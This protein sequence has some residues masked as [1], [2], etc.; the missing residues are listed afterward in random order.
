MNHPPK[1]LLR[2]LR[3]FCRPELL[4]YIEGD[5]LELYEEN[6]RAKG[7]TQANWL[8]AWEVVKL[9]RPGVVKGGPYASNIL[10]VHSLK[11]SFRYFRRNPFY[12]GIN[13]LGLV[14]GI[15]SCLLI[16]LWVS[17]ERSFDSFH[18]NAD[19]LYRVSCNS[20]EFH[21][22]VSPGA[23][24][25][26]LAERYDFV[27]SVSR[28]RGGYERV[29]EAG[30]HKFKESKVFS[31]DENFFEMFTYPL[32]HGSPETALDAPHKIV[33]S[34]AIAFKYFGQSDAVGEVLRLDGE[35]EF[36][37]SGVFAEVPSNS[38]LDFDLV[39]PM[40]YSQS[41]SQWNYDTSWDEFAFR[42]YMEVQ[43]AA[44]D[45]GEL[46]LLKQE[47]SELYAVHE[48][49]FAVQFNIEPIESIHLFNDL[50]FDTDPGG[51]RL[52][53]QVLA[54][55][56]LLIVLIACINY[57]NF[58][59]AQ[60]S[61][62]LKEVWVRR[63]V[64][65]QRGQLV[66]YFLV[67]AMMYAGMGVGLSLGIIY[68]L[69]PLFSKFV[70]VS[71]NLSWFQWQHVLT[72]FALLMLVGLLAGVY[73]AF[74]LSKLNSLSRQPSGKG[75]YRWL[76]IR[77][78]LVLV[79]FVIFLG[80]ISANVILSKQLDFI[81]SKDLG[82]DQEDLIYLRM[83]EELINSDLLLQELE[84]NGVDQYSFV[85]DL[86]IN[87]GQ[88]NHGL[89]WEGK[90]PEL[91]AVI[92][93]MG[94]DKHFLQVFQA[95][96]VS[97]RFFNADLK[98]D[99]HHYVIN[100][101][102]ARLMGYTAESALGKWLDLHGKG[103]II[104][105]IED[106]HFKPLHLAVE[107]M[108]LIYYPMGNYLVVR[109]AANHLQAKMDGIEKVFSKLDPN[110]YF[111]YQYLHDGIEQLYAVENRMGRVFKLFV[112][113]SVVISCLGLI[114]LTS[115]MIDTRLKEIGIRKVLGVTR[116]GL[117]RLLTQQYYSLFVLSLVLACPVTYLFMSRWLEAFAY[118]IDLS[119]WHFTLS[120]G[121]GMLIIGVTV[122]FQL[123]KIIATNPTQLLRDE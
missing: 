112:F 102:A 19:R 41:V 35:E 13:L 94:A 67:E 77:S 119:F 22:A 26:A 104:G 70:E 3:W 81:R 51:D 79:Q 68:L 92:P 105:V 114:G 48:P 4:R 100:E 46:T 10:M 101:S 123:L 39:V 103:N 47:L 11:S 59:S 56:A 43:G 72:A 90:D 61:A 111:E 83:S 86:P 55:I 85:S 33:I 76:N 116:L 1:L 5:L 21:T 96:L 118:R 91:Q 113:L 53:V 84:R 95:Q 31:A 32:L 15:T 16:L 80:L 107:P 65:A 120:A 34:Q 69:L 87:M 122:S 58:S 99:T 29:F 73:P 6:A 71:L 37:V 44:L 60:A 14:T 7:A 40:L 45:A 57:A 74:S 98:T 38:H 9:F 64:G 25:G 75:N 49:E 36:M 30:Q 42:T 97:G 115:Y 108:V 8:F 106:F 109:A 54:L 63:S 20:G 117:V 88:A 12:S 50:Q 24:A 110:L 52:Y 17:H 18:E 66:V 121:F 89:D 28:L 93:N 27:K 82:F 2:F 62:R 78:M 23:L